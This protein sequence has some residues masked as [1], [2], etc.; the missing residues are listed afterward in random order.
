MD[1]QRGENL[2]WELL[3]PDFAILSAGFHSL[4]LL[5]PDQ[6]SA[7]WRT[8]HVYPVPFLA[9]LAGRCSGSGRI[10]GTQKARLGFGR[11]DLDERDGN[12]LYRRELSAAYSEQLDCI[13]V[14][15]RRAAPCIAPGSGRNLSSCFSRIK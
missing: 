5:L 7:F 1:H 6:S 13:R 11:M 3:P 10:L 15:H 9:L 8:D 14:Q 12:F 4:Y 2:F